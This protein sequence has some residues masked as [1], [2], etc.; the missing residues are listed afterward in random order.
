MEQK[1]L[2]ST[3]S[4]RIRAAV[5]LNQWFSGRCVF[6]VSYFEAVRAALTGNA[7][8]LVEQWG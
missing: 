6:P 7:P 8:H 5:R 2:S 4:L 1:V 3:I